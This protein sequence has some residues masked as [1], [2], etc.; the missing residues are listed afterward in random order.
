MPV[1]TLANPFQ[2]ISTGRPFINFFAPDQNVYD[3][4]QY[5]YNLAIEQ[6]WGG[7]AFTVEYEGR[8]SVVLYGAEL[9]AV[10]GPTVLLW[11]RSA[12]AN[13]REKE[14]AIVEATMRSRRAQTQGALDDG[15]CNF[16]DVARTIFGCRS[17]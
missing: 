1:L 9:N 13:I 4:K 17:T 12:K 8:H 16:E 10:P 14:A 15:P 7:N 2:G 6:Q 5:S 11:L 3:P